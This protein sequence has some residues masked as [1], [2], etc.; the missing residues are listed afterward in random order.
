MLGVWHPELCPEDELLRLRCRGV[1]LSLL[2]AFRSA[3]PYEYVHAN[4]IR[5][6]W[7]LRRHAWARQPASAVHSH[8]LALHLMKSLKADSW[9]SSRALRRVG[10]CSLFPSGLPP[11]SFQE[12]ASIVGDRP[13]DIL[14]PTACPRQML[15]FQ[16]V[17]ISSWLWGFHR[18]M[19]N[20]NGLPG[21]RSSAG[22]ERRAGDWDCPECNAHNFASKEACYRCGLTK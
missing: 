13:G 14:A 2:F 3:R 18:I 19:R 9:S 21:A 15:G 8:A 17:S 12:G 20:G 5:Q 10:K 4:I 1:S 11:T 6:S 16:M 22:P 7:V